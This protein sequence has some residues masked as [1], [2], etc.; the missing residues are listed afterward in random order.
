[1][2]KPLVGFKF[3]YFR[4]WIM[5][6]QEFPELASRSVL[7]NKN[8]SRKKFNTIKVTEENDVEDSAE[9]VLADRGK[10]NKNK[11][12]VNLNPTKKSF[13]NGTK[14][15]ESCM[16]DLVPGIRKRGEFLEK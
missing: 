16:K 1:M 6:L 11:N 8:Q 14:I 9:W 12:H 5:N 4:A 10:F 15:K 7:A 13:R 3:H 2:S